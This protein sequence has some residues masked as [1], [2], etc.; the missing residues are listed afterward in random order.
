MSPSR[1]VD[2][3][4][5]AGGLGDPRVPEHGRQRPT[6]A[7]RLRDLDVIVG[8]LAVVDPDLQAV[9]R[10]VLGEDRFEASPMWPSSF[11]IATRSETIG[12]SLISV[13]VG[14]CFGR[15]RGQMLTPGPRREP[16]RVAGH[17][18]RAPCRARDDP[19]EDG[20]WSPLVE[21][22]LPMLISPLDVPGAD[23]PYRI[24]RSRSIADRLAS[25]C[26]VAQVGQIHVRRAP[27]WCATMSVGRSERASDSALAGPAPRSAAAA[28]AWTEERG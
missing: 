2:P 11:R 27:V 7:H 15:R 9:R 21:P 5:P 22:A 3:E 16:S 13:T 25:G 23:G 19:I 12:G 1:L 10:V 14:R 18:H 8:R 26:T 6:G 17:F 28:L 4:V 20:A 24:F